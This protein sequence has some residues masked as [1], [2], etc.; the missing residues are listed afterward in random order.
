MRDILKDKETSE[1]QSEGLYYQAR[2]NGVITRGGHD[3]RMRSR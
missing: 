3:R 2:S 1:R